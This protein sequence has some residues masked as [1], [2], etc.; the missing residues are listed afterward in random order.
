MTLAAYKGHEP[1]LFLDYLDL[2]TGKALYA[3]PGGTYDMSPVGSGRLIPD[4]PE[5]W[6]TPVVFAKGGIV[7][8]SASLG[9]EADIA[10]PAEDPVPDEDRETDESQ[11][12]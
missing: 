6:F 5:Q 2:G 1:R 12:F 9:S 7:A 11:Q 4:V 3:E 10:E 8:A